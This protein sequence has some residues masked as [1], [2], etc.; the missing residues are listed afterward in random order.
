MRQA[1]YAAGVMLVI[2]FAATSVF[3]GTAAPSRPDSAFWRAA[4]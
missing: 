1:V 3:A 2:V 4:R